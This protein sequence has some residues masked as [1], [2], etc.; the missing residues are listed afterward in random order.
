MDGL[1]EVAEYPLCDS[2]LF[3]LKTVHKNSSTWLCTVSCDTAIQQNTQKLK[4]LQNNAKVK[5]LLKQV[6]SLIPSAAC[7]LE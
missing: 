4:T 1:G 6:F 3:G 5:I 7:C 2:N